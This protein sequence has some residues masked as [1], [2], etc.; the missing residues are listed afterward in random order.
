M[1]VEFRI[2]SI[3]S[4][5]SF[6]T[7]SF[8]RLLQL[9]QFTPP[10]NLV[11]FPSRSST[12]E[13]FRP[14]IVVQ[15]VIGNV[16]CIESLMMEGRLDQKWRKEQVTAQCGS[17]AIRTTRCY[18]GSAQAIVTSLPWIDLERPVKIRV[19]QLAPDFSDDESKAIRASFPTYFELR[20]PRL[21]IGV[22]KISLRNLLV[23]GSGVSITLQPKRNVVVPVEAFNGI[24]TRTSGV[25][26]KETGGCGI[27]TLQAVSMVFSSKTL[28]SLLRPTRSSAVTHPN[29]ALSDQ[30]TQGGNVSWDLVSGRSLDSNSEILLDLREQMNSESVRM[31]L[32]PYVVAVDALLRWNDAFSWRDPIK[33]LLLLAIVCVVISADIVGFGLLLALVLQFVAAIRALIFFYRVPI[34]MHDSI[35]GVCFL[36]ERKGTFQAVLYG[37]HNR[38]INSMVRARLFFSQGL[39]Q[40]CYLELAYIFYHIKQKCHRVFFWL[41][42]LPLVL[43]LMSIETLMALII[44]GVFFIHPLLLRVPVSSMR[45]SWRQ[46]LSSGT[47]WKALRLS[48]PMR[49]QRVAQ[50]T[51]PV[52]KKQATLMPIPLAP[53]YSF[54]KS[55]S[56]LSIPS[57]A[58]CAHQ[59]MEGMRHRNSCTVA[60]DRMNATGRFTEKGHGAFEDF[61]RMSL[62]DTFN[63]MEGTYETVLTAN[64][65]YINGGTCADNTARTFNS[66][67]RAISRKTDAARLDAQQMSL[68]SFVVVTISHEP[69]HLNNGKVTNLSTSQGVE[70]VIQKLRRLL[71]RSNALQRPPLPTVQRDQFNSYFNSALSVLQFLSRQCSL[72]AYIT[73][74]P[75]SV[76]Y[77]GASEK[78]VKLEQVAPARGLIQKGDDGGI[79]S[80]LLVHPTQVVM[81]KLSSCSSA[82]HSTRAFALL[83]AYLLQGSRL[84]L[85]REGSGRFCSVIIPL[86]MGTGA[87]NKA[88][89]PHPCPLSLQKALVGFW[90][91]WTEDERSIDVTP[92]VVLTVI[93]TYKDAWNGTAEGSKSG[94]GCNRFT[95]APLNENGSNIDASK[96]FRRTTSALPHPYDHKLTGS[97]VLPPIE[98]ELRTAK[99]RSPLPLRDA[100]VATTVENYHRP[101]H[102]WT[103]HCWPMRKP[104]RSDAFCDLP[105][106]ENRSS[107]KDREPSPP[108]RKNGE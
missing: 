50:V 52:G 46:Q 97:C 35:D 100:K 44:V 77:Q 32:V 45:K 23:T 24:T 104:S 2:S 3:E 103:G 60:P 68:L 107:M 106:A 17:V 78:V 101:S 10:E 18:C 38:I 99:S 83:A 89:E 93:T 64:S 57:M 21:C 4:L 12:G 86:E 61:C 39:Q 91:G 71:E 66:S 1:H 14:R 55:N 88:P 87:I 54:M 81:K 7:E 94:G 36:A 28:L 13:N 40:D 84:S 41:V 8:V 92:D 82:E 11:S 42:W 65:N 72:E 22:V 56:T 69:S 67:S 33:S 27:L 20:H 59:E 105:L 26:E 15:F 58:P 63:A 19:L 62:S 73:S 75:S 85:Y 90:E 96:Q 51:L 98:S 5:C 102:T 79:T 9:K 43:Y 16:L 30:N 76:N 70:L 47:L 29:G 95:N 80:T 74:S 25:F 37:A 49:I 53:S 6:D 48:Q 108:C 34:C 31:V